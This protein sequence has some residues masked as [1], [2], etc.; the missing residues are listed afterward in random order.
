MSGDTKFDPTSWKLAGAPSATTSPNAGSSSG[1]FSGLIKGVDYLSVDLSL[2]GSK[3]ITRLRHSI[4]L[5]KGLT[6]LVALALMFHYHHT[7]HFAGWLYVGLH[8][9]YCVLWIAKDYTFPDPRWDVPQTAG[10]FVVTLTVL[11]GYW[12]APLCLNAY[13]YEPSNVLMLCSTMLCF[14]GSSLMFGADCQKYYQLKFARGLITSGFY[15]YTRNPNY[16][17]EMILYAG[18]ALL[19]G[20]W[21]P[22]LYLGV[23]WTGLFLPSMLRK[24]AS[25]SRYPQW[26]RYRAQSGLLIPNFMACFT[27]LATEP[28]KD[29]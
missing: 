7:R 16:L 26:A 8:G 27:D 23:I 20:H 10:G 12:M 28:T 1:L 18:F 21:L 22:W 24:D 4:N 17:G 3:K 14:L 25:L 6:L 11:A 15:K 19:A 2:L 13:H 9:S 5:G 29:S